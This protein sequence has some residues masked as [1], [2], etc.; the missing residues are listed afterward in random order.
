MGKHEGWDYLNSDD[1]ESLFEKDGNWGYQ[2]E[3]GSG[4]FN[5]AD[6][7]W[8]YKNSDGSASYNGAD[9]SWGYRN[10]DGSVSWNGAD[11]SWAYRNSDGSGSFYD[12]NGDYE[13]LDEYEK[14][15]DE[16]SNSEYTSSSADG[17][18]SIGEALGAF[19]AVFAL[20]KLSDRKERKK[21][22]QEEQRI[23]AAEYEVER[24]RQEE[25]R[26]A[27]KIEKK[28]KKE[29]KREYRKKHW[30]SYLISR[31]VMILIVGLS[32]CGAYYFYLS[33]QLIEIPFTESS[34]VGKQ[35]EETRGKYRTLGFEKVYTRCIQDLEYEQIENDGIVTNITFSDDNKLATNNKHSKNCEITI[36]YHCLKLVKAPFSSKDAKKMNYVEAVESLKKNGFVNIEIEANKDLI[37][38]WINKDGEVDSILINEDDEFETGDSFKVDSKVKVVYH[39]FKNKG[40]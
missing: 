18:A 37:F 6:G 39:T 19:A 10:E 12:A 7:S 34:V 16:D 36:E 40:E 27:Q 23:R 26:K 35:I 28:K 11:G 25:E 29:Q 5:G 32:I 21:Q 15:N 33:S 24:K 22:E 8:G 38:G 31:I 14:E 3:D 17:E 13:S 9:G 2:N 20:K 30:K 4:S 1:N